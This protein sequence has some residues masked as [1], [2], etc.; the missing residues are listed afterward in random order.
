MAAM[1]TASE[2]MPPL[3]TKLRAAG[4]L[5]TAAAVAAVIPMLAP[6]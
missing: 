3:A 1:E 6:K 2:I 5:K 4:V